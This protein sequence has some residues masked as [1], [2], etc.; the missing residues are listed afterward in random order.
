LSY[1]AIRFWIF[2]LCAVQIIIKY[3]RVG[4]EKAY[5]F[6]KQYQTIEDVGNNAKVDISVLK[7]I[8]VRF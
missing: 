6:I 2:V 1:L 5:K 8:R 7:H 3:F 4:P